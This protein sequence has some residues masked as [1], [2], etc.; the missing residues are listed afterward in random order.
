MIRSY[1]Q[2]LNEGRLNLRRKSAICGKA[3]FI[4]V[5]NINR[6]G[7]LSPINIESNSVEHDL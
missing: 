2:E 5:G 3:F 4:N 7:C 1:I 6:M